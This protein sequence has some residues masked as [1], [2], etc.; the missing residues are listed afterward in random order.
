[1]SFILALRLLG[2]FIGAVLQFS[3]LALVRRYRQIR[4]VE[5]VFL[6]LTACLLIWNFCK[7]LALLIES[8]HGTT[9]M[10]QFFLKLGPVPLAYCALWVIP[11]LL[12]H[13]H[14]ALGRV[15]LQWRVT[16]LFRIVEAAAYLPLVA[17]PSH[18]VEFLGDYPSG[19]PYTRSFATWLAL[20]LLSSAV[21]E[22]L[23]L[24]RSRKTEE[25][26]LFWVL[27]TIFATT[28]LLILYA[29]WI[30]EY[31]P[32]WNTPFETL[33]M[34]SSI[35]P[36]AILTY[37]VFHY[38]FLDVVI[39]RSIGYMFAA[40]LFLMIYFAGVGWVRDLLHDAIEFPGIVVDAGMILALFAFFQPV[41]HW[42]DKSVDTFYAAE[43]AKF[44]NLAVRLND[45][46]RTTVEV[47]KLVRFM[48]DLLQRELALSGVRILLYASGEGE[49]PSSKPEP[50]GT[51]RDKNE[52]ILLPRGK[53][54]IGEIQVVEEL[55]HLSSEQRA[56]L[57]FLVTQIVAAI[58]NCKL[59]EG[60][61]LLER[62]LAEKD[63]LATLGQAAATVAH[64]I[65]NPLS[66]IKTI[67]Q[68]I[69]EDKECNHRYDRDLSLV[70][71]EI[72][73]LTNSVRQLLDFS[74]QTPIVTEVTLQQVL[75]KVYLLF[76]PEAQRRGICLELQQ[77][78]VSLVVLGN[79]EVLAEVFQNLLVN[80]LEI[81][82]PQTCIQIRA[83]AYTGN[84]KK[85]A[86]VHVE[87]QGPGI[88]AS[89]REKV[90]K[91][92][93]TTKQK[94][95]GLGLAI[96]QRRV[97]DMGGQVNVV[98]PVAES[99]GTRFELIFPLIA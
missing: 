99:R 3:L 42:V 39:D 17:L 95:T 76:Q 49:D 48:E 21:M 6:W 66:S 11:S 10:T 41:R 92:F 75:Q 46:S 53:E 35:I 71:N 38:R 64:N 60:K 40:I 55:G 94:G 25:R 80:A 81:S 69:Q 57:Q 84:H 31:Q 65:R 32:E 90:F 54:I 13:T 67:I 16:R 78:P 91:P 23:L 14:I 24:R 87:D 70:N 82:A 77:D 15:Y 30:E 36:S 58:E 59:S 33:L 74:K 34:L 18:L 19:S 68:L 47:E 27:T 12:L 61:I 52:K 45:A 7:F 9:P 5:S 22:V 56:G 85:F 86:A 98:S 26:R 93:F 88:P 79:A 62:K 97:M 72:D 51:V 96:V 73:R 2:F 4:K 28:A 83:F 50:K 1:M 44:Q 43:I 20:A 37:T 89:L 8:T 29:F 63:M